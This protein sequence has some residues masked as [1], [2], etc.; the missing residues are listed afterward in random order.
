[1]APNHP[2]YTAYLGMVAFLY[3]AWFWTHGGQTLGMRAWRIRLAGRGGEP[4][5]WS[6][7][8]LR[9]LGA[10]VSLACAGA[11]YLWVLVDR[12]RMTWHDRLSATVLT[13]EAKA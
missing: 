3:F 4:V 9:F 13:V 1:M 12:E 11:G 7:A 2:L 8:L 10:A 6:L 5:T